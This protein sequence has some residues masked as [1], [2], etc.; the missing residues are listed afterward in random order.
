MF[1]QKNTIDEKSISSKLQA[2]QLCH[3]GLSLSYCANPDEIISQ[4]SP[5]VLMKSFPPDGVPALTE[6]DHFFAITKNGA[7]VGFFRVI[8][9][10]F[11]GEI[12]LHGSYNN[13]TGFAIRSYFE[14]G[15]IFV[16]TIAKL[17]PKK[18]ISATALHTNKPVQR[19][20]GY[21]EFVCIGPLKDNNLF[22]YYTFSTKSI[23]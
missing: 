4:L 1:F 3:R 5:N 9:L 21:L 23:K 10:Y 15:R 8:D 14:L 18:I 13:E 19:F 12:Q 20:L 2:I 7:F 17:F 6:L 22:D 16:Q 11:Y